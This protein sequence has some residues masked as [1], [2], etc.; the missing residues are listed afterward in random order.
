MRV[1]L[2]Q[3]EIGQDDAPGQLKI[4]RDDL[5][6]GAARGHPDLDG[7]DPLDSPPWSRDQLDDGPR[8]KDK[9][10]TIGIELAMTVPG[11][12]ALVAERGVLVRHVQWFASE[13]AGNVSDGGDVAPQAGRLSLRGGPNIDD[14]D[15]VFLLSRLRWPSG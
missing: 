10:N 1:D 8:L 3:R 6:K 7:F 12:L 14:G 9:G 4:G 15:V 5:H 11:F 2:R 13:L